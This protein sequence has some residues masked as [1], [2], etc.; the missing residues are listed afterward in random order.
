MLGLIKRNIDFH[1][2]TH[3]LVSDETSFRVALSLF[4]VSSYK[5]RKMLKKMHK[6]VAWIRFEGRGGALSFGAL[7]AFYI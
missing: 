5:D 7:M 4:G 1:L 3:F 2:K 6:Y